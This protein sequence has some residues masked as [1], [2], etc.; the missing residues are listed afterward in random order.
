MRGS[1]EISSARRVVDYAKRSLNTCWKDKKLSYKELSWT[2][3]DILRLMDIAELTG[4]RNRLKAEIIE[5]DS[6]L[7][8][9]W[10]HEQGVMAKQFRE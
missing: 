2:V 10:I 9:L 6:E 3:G 7:G 5:E 8:V 1:S 4:F